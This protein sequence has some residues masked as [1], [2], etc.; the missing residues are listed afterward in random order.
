MEQ[1][2]TAIAPKIDSKCFLEENLS[3]FLDNK[4][5]LKVPIY[6][7]FSKVCDWS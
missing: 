3:K 7:G 2:L 5:P 6:K 4:K 1:I